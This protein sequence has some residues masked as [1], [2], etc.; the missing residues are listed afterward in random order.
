MPSDLAALTPPLLIAIAFLISVGAFIRHEMRRGRN[1]AEDEQGTDSGHDSPT[2]SD[3]IEPN[4]ASP[5][6]S[7]GG[8]AADRK[9]GS[10]DPSDRDS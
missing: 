4:P 9:Q 5:R 1:R 3:A 2:E 10:H 8:S 6:R 7:F